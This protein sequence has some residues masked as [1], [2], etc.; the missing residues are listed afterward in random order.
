[1]LHIKGEIIISDEVDSSDYLCV[2]DLI[3]DI[4]YSEGFYL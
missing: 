4:E 2:E 3:D 1:M